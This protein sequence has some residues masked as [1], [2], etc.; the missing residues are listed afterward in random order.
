M[1]WT[2]IFVSAAFALV[3]AGSVATFHAWFA[4]RPVN[5]ILLTVESLR[6]DRFTEDLA[7]NFFAAARHATAFKNHRSIAAWTGPNI[8]ALLTGITPFEQG[9]HSRGQSIAMERDVSLERLARAGWKIGSIQAFAKTENFRN[10]GMPVSAGETFEGWIARRKLA[11]APFF[12]W[13]HYLDTHLPYD[14]PHQFI[15]QDVSFPHEGDAAYERIQ[16]VRR[17]PAVRADSVYFNAADRPYIDALYEGGIRQFDAWF[18]QF[19]RFF[20]TTGLRDD[21]I[22]IVTADHGEELLERN[23][24]GHAST[25]TAG[26]LFEEVVRIP[27]FIWWPKRMGRIEGVVREAPSDHLDVMPTV[28]DLLGDPYRLSLPGKSLLRKRETYQWI[29]LTSRAG[30]AEADPDHIRN[31][32]AA[33]VQANWKLVAQAD[34]RSLVAAQLYDL[35]TDPAET[36]NQAEARPEILMRLL[37]PLLK[38]LSTFTLPKSAEDRTDGRSPAIGVAPQWVFPARSRVVSW[39]DLQGRNFLQWSGSSAKSYVLNIQPV[40]T[41][42]PYPAYFGRW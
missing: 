9:V 32:V 33:T 10:L 8:I 29:A 34:G 2:S 6:A 25:S 27:L 17:R 12:F 13:H 36:T 16:A 37:P 39:D 31:F 40:R 1:R 42:L 3:L 15:A 23:N 22:L 41:R 4:D 38:R 18:Q 14:P 26:T 5:V 7:P 20:N 24:V 35:S 11:G 28:L 21:T 19:W 30:F